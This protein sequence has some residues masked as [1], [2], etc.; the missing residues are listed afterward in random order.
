MI[1]VDSSVWIDFLRGNTAT[2]TR[3]AKAAENERLAVSGYILHEVLRGCRTQAQFDRYQREMQ[4]WER[5][6][7]AEA[8]FVRSAQLY[9]KLR[10][11]GVTVPASDCLIAATALRLNWPLFTEDADFTHIPNLRLYQAPV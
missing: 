7:E 11:S 5:V 9:A 2:A 6:A 1:L 8:D 10:W 4:L 3:L